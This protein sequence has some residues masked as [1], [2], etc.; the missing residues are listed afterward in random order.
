[1]IKRVTKIEK[2]DWPREL[3]LL[4][5]KKC[6]YNC[7]FPGTCRE[8]CHKDGVRG[9]KGE[10]QIATLEDYN[11]L[12]G[13]LRKRFNLEKIK[14]GAMEPLLFNGIEKIILAAK[15]AKYKEISLTTNGY[16]LSDKLELL[17]ECG[18]DTLTVSMHAFNS[19]GYKKITRV[20]GFE[21]VK[22]ALEKASKMGFR[23]VKVNRVLLKTDDLWNDLQNFFEWAGKY[24]INVKLYKLIW[25]PE[26]DE[27]EYFENFVAW[28][29]LMPFLEKKGKLEEINNYSSSGRERLK[30]RLENGVLVETD[31]FHH[32]L[33]KDIAKQC[34]NC[35]YSATCLEGLMS[36]GIEINSDL[37]VSACLLRDDLD[38]SISKEVKS[39][40]EKLLVEK[41]NSFIN[42]LL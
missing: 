33:G 40:D 26:M 15:E 23:E 24:K 13:V 34:N 10:S 4:I 25:S 16:F 11:F 42:K 32:K 12:I 29:S 18:L 36:F 20:D 6:N 14:I 7:S 19:E 1:M 5:N 35:A 39:R 38:I 9:Q 3:R 22:K 8:W 41:V 27:R 21:R 2:Y 31:I 37:G 17:K 30:W 28:E